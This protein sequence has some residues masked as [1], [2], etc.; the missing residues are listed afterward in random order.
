MKKVLAITLVIVMLLSLTIL[1]SAKTKDEKV[2]W[3]NRFGTPEFI[4]GKLTNPSNENAEDIVLNYIV[5]NKEN[6]KLGNEISKSSFKLLEKN[7]DKLGYTFMRFQQVYKGVPVYGFTQTAHVKDGVLTSIS[8]EI[9]PN[10][11]NKSKLK[12]E[13]KINR[14]KAIEIAEKDLGFEALYEEKP[15][16][17]LVVY[18]SDNEVNYAYQVNLNFLSPE[19]GNWNYFIDAATGKIIDKHNNLKNLPK[20]SGGQSTVSTGIGVLGD[21]KNI[22]TYLNSGLYYL[23]DVTRGK[24][25]ETYDSA[26]STQ[27][28][29]TLWYDSDNELNNSYDRAAVDAHYY[30]G[31]TYDYYLQTF[32]RNSYDDRGTTMKASVHFYRDYNNAFWNGRQ[33]VFGD[34]DG[35][36]FREFSGAID[37]VAHELTHAVTDS[38][39]SLVYKNESGA[40]NESM[41]DIFGTAVEFFNGVKPDW[42][43]GEDLDLNSSDG[44]GFRSMSN[45]TQFGDPD[46]YNDRYIGTLDDGGVHWNSGIM[47]KAAYLI[48][49]GGTHYGVNVSGIGM[50]KM[51]EIFYRG[52]TQHFTRST[53]F[54]QARAAL[55][56]SAIELY[57][58]NG[59]EVQAVNDAFDSVGVY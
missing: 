11:D 27:L 59:A 33:M 21:T 45:P 36:D 8:G 15:L 53:T 17:E 29:G 9:V 55:V 48:S 38:T 57:G 35:I 30:L 24:G 12:L 32:G 4:S 13:N 34:G 49:E 51:N 7:N 37:V 20:P 31:K 44:I 41:S 39:A 16:S 40:L 19:P 43:M 42:I 22:N 50:D 2:V 3:G 14:N 58:A 47:N 25:I 1:T 23:K 46:H 26:Y 10:L 56:Q 18:I 52:L 54:S 6:Y 5:N 28:P